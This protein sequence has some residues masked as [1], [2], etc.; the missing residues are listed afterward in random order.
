MNDNNEV[1]TIRKFP[2][3]NNFDLYENK[4]EKMWIL[5]SNGI[6]VVPADEL[7]ANGEISPVYYS[8]D[9]GLPCITTAN[10]YS[11]LTEDGDL[12]IAGTTG[13]AKVN[14]EKS[15]EDVGKIKMSVPYIEGDGVRFYADASG[16]ITIPS[17]I[18]KITV[19]EYVYTYSLINPQV[20][21]Y[22][23][24]LSDNVTTVKRSELNPVDYTNLKGG[25]Y[26]FVMQLKDEH[27]K[28]SNEMSVRI[29]KEKA[30]TETIWFYVLMAIL[31]A[32]V[33]AVMV[34]AYIR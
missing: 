9:N 17:N 10:S 12:Y 1:T 25:E 8:G 26:S 21:Y 16:T 11:E 27:G 22:L 2:Y 19:Y 3:S 24:G 29:V 32:A 7:V 28:G 5:S 13:I 30:F 4:D 6:Y 34:R 23:K 18:N 15:F 33:I 20:S 31:L 14:I